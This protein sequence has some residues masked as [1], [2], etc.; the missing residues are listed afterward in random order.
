MANENK[1]PEEGLDEEFI[2]GMFSMGE[3]GAQI[4]TKD[5]LKEINKHLPS[6]S[7]RPPVKYQEDKKTDA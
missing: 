2:S 3:D 1:K 5:Q 4:F 6:W 7:I